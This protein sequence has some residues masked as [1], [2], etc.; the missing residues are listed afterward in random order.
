MR[1]RAAVRA[2]P[3]GS[4]GPHGGAGPHGGDRSGARGLLGSPRSAPAGKSTMLAAIAGL[5]PTAKGAI[6]TNG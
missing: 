2:G 6:Y 1:A 4:P 3:H 5:L